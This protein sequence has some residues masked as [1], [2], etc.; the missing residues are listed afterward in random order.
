MD[1]ASSNLVAHVMN[2]NDDI[3]MDDPDIGLSKI[4]EKMWDL[5]TLGIKDRLCRRHF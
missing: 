2:V 3:G 1:I 4:V 5:E